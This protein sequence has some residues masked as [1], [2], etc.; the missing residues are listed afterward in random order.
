MNLQRLEHMSH[1][2]KPNKRDRTRLKVKS[3]EDSSGKKRKKKWNNCRRVK[4]TL[5]KKMN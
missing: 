2:N 1:T 4:R 5:Q 3:T